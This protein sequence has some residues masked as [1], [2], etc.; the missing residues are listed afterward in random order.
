VQHADPQQLAA[1]GDVVVRA[2]ASVGRSSAAAKRTVFMRI[3]FMG[4][5]FVVP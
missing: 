2:N 5:P 3:V 4:I 1:A